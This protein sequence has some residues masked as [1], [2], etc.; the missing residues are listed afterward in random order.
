M[1]REARYVEKKM[2]Q[3]LTDEVFKR[4]LTEIERVKKK[5]ERWEEVHSKF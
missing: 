3:K 4:R 1:K 5:K 2:N